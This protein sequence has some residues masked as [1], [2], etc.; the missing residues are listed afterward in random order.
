MGDQFVIHGFWRRLGAF[1][2]GVVPEVEVVRPPAYVRLDANGASVAVPDAEGYPSAGRYF[3]RPRIIV[4]W[5]SAQRG[6]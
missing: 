4:G 5:N 6:A 2:F 1:L 3:P